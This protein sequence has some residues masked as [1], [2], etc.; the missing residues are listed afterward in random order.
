MTKYHRKV[1]RQLHLPRTHWNI[2]RGKVHK[3][4]LPYESQEEAEEFI[5]V[6]HLQGYTS[7]LCPVCNK[8][9]IGHK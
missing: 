4:K 2:Q 3:A 1:P 8:Y 6:H 9:H 7:Y 5:E